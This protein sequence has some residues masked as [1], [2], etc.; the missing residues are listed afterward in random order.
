MARATLPVAEFDGGA[1]RMEVD[2]DDATGEVLALRCV[3]VSG[4]AARVELW[5]VA[6]V[7][8]GRVTGEREVTA[9]EVGRRR[10]RRDRRGRLDGLELVCMR[11]GSD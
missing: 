6:V 3:N 11:R 8:G 10:L 4:E 9:A 5:G 2:Y 7:F 1:V